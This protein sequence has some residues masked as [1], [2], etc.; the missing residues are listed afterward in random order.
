M[1]TYMHTYINQW[2]EVSRVA[3]L[4][5]SSLSLV[6]LTDGFEMKMK[7][8]KKWDLLALSIT[9]PP[10]ISSRDLFVRGEKKRMCDV[11]NIISQHKLS[12]SSLG[13]TSIDRY[14]THFISFFRHAQKILI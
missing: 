7:V 6:C 2:Q 4:F 13:L 14:Y 11:T 3:W 12:P 9:I 8:N 1:H 5:N 10:S